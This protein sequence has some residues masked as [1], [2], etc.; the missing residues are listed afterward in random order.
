MHRYRSTR[1]DSPFSRHFLRAMVH[2]SVI[3]IL[4]L[5][6]ASEI[7]IAGLVGFRF[8]LDS[9]LHVA[10]AVTEAPLAAARGVDDAAPLVTAAREG[11]LAATWAENPAVGDVVVEA[12]QGGFWKRSDSCDQTNLECAAACNVACVL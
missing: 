7:S 12:M 3:R 9:G 4:R 11:R 8:L 5:R 2:L 1:K 10:D 6:S